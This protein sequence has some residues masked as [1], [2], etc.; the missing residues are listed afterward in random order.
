MGTAMSISQPIA[1][2]AGALDAARAD[3]AMV[4]AKIAELEN[5]RREIAHAPPHTDDIVAVFMRG[6]ES[7]SV[8]FERQLAS[9]L[10]ANFLGIDG[11]AAT[12][13]AKSRSSNILRLEAQ[14]PDP[15]TVLT[16]S[17]Q[18]GGPRVPKLNGAVLAYFLRD[19][20][21][22][23]IPALVD[24]LCPDARQGTKAADRS[25]AL[26]EIDATIERLRGQSA[27]IQA[28]LDAARKAVFPGA[29]Y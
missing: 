22:A 23:E 28:D 10:S 2:F 18:R 21:A 20:M 5:Q 11:A 4:N 14:K 6:L 8:D 16:R 25:R 13:A 3:L 29:S 27:A 24:R 9:H 7:A 19:K 12:A 1:D 26:D 17:M 15:E